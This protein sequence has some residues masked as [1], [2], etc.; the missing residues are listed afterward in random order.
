VWT[1]IISRRKIGLL[2]GGL[3]LGIT[4]LFIYSSFC[5]DVW[6]AQSSLKQLR[7]L[8]DPGHGGVDGGTS[9]SKGNL[10]KQINLDISLR[11]R[12]H[13]SQSGL[14]VFLTRETDIDLASFNILGRGRH[15]RDLMARIAKA[16]DNR[17]R[18]LVSLHC[19]WSKNPQKQGATVFYYQPS[20]AGRRL[21]EVI[22]AEL[23]TLQGVNRKANPGNFFII[24]Q[25]GVT[26][27]IVE[28]GMLSNQHEAV[29]LQNS[30]YQEQLAL[31]IAKGILTY[32]RDY[33]LKEPPAFHNLFNMEKME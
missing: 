14:R 23:N 29:M 6:K 5:S 16:R 28:L 11:V 30:N 31:A 25:H 8:I 7:V 9:D 24:K 17:C 1:I 2:L 4:L 27:V 33:M 10:E 26:G 19:D 22:Q 12:D 13:L 21:A 15:Q 20:A 3:V 32:C 18:F